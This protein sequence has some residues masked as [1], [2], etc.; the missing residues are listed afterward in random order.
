MAETSELLDKY[1]DT[2]NGS[3]S[4]EKRREIQSAQ[5][6]KRRLLSSADER[7]KENAKASSNQLQGLE[8][9]REERKARQEGNLMFASWKALALRQLERRVQVEQQQKQQRAEVV[10]KARQIHEMNVL[11]AEML[12]NTRIISSG[13]IE[14]SFDVGGTELFRAM[15]TELDEQYAQ[16]DAVFKGLEFKT[17]VPASSSY[18]TYAKVAGSAD[19]MEF[20]YDMEHIANVASMVM[21]NDPQVD[22]EKLHIQDMKETITA[23][24]HAKYQFKPGKYADVDLYGAAKTYREKNRVVFVMRWFTEGFGEFAGF[25]SNE[26]FWM[27]IRPSEGICG[28]TVV[29]SYSRLVPMNFDIS[30]EDMDKFLTFLVQLGEEESKQMVDMMEKLLNTQP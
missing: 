10:G 21:M 26:T 18:K 4:A 5:A 13:L 12:Q 11:V 1:K 23:K 16:T 20:P 7:R 25:N 6:A 9:A 17:S 3:L 19:R 8:T 24:Y 29:E 22:S 28:F 2:Q 14:A 30:D 15:L 27:V